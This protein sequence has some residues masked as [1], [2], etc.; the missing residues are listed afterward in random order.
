MIPQEKF[1]IRLK[2]EYKNVM[3]M[4]ES[5]LMMVAPAPDQE[6][7][8]VRSYIVRYNIPT[9]INKGESLQQTTV[10]RVDIPA[11]YPMS[12]PTA[13]VVQGSVPFHVN[14]W[15]DGRMDNG[16]FWNWDR[17][18]WEYMVFI[19]ESLMFK[20]ECMNVHCPSNQDA[21]S[22]CK[23]NLYRFPTIDCEL[24]R[25]HVQKRFTILSN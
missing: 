1:N 15:S 19:G 2:N 14:W 9:F 5:E 17:Y 23:N 18:I 3:L 10:V 6:P 22:F 16:N 11:S 24:P 13:C 20:P 21:V 8:Y 25:P 4:E 7:P 12:S